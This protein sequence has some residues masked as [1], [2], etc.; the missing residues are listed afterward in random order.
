MFDELI[1][2]LKDLDGQRVPID[3]PLDDNGYFDRCCPSLECG[4]QF[5]V[6]F[7]DWRDIVRDEEV[8]C[9]KCRHADVATEWN[10]PE[11]KEYIKASGEA[12]MAGELRDALKA[13]A[14]KQNAKARESSFLKITMSYREGC[15]PIPVPISARDVMTQEARCNQCATRY[16]SIGNM[17]F[18][19]SCGTGT[20]IENFRSTVDTVRKTVDAIGSFSNTLSEQYDENI[21]ADA[22]RQIIESSLVKLVASFQKYAEERFAQLPNASA[23]SPRRNLFQNLEESN[24]IWKDATGLGYVDHLTPLEMEVL[25][26]LFQQRHLL[27]HQE[28][29]VDGRYQ[30]KAKDTRF[31]VGQR[32]TVQPSDVHSLAEL[33]TKLESRLA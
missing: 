28:G 13:D 18:C 15:A 19:P 24:K 29:I 27:S 22:C 4:E 21:A 8:F 5:K 20:I 30:Q 7:E 32:L 1:R 2:K 3:L 25:N 26:R 31:S 9:P 6:L 23:F 16:S 33:L 14:R 17:F 12:F 10:T 11:Q